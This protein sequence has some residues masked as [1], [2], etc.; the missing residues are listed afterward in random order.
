[1]IKAEKALIKEKEPTLDQEIGA[2]SQEQV[3]DVHQKQESEHHQEPS[4]NLE[5]HQHENDAGVGNDAGNDGGDGGGGD[6]GS[7]E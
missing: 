5:S 1:M 7:G 6:G 2:G 3:E 4:Q